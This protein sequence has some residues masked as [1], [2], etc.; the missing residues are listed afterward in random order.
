M[1]SKLSVPRLT[2]SIRYSKWKLKMIAS[3]KRQDLYE[4]S[5]GIGKDSYEYENDC[6]NDNDR[7]FGTICLALSPSFLYLVK[8]VEYPNDLWTKLDRT[9][10]KNNEDHYIKLESTSN[11]TRVL[12]SKVVQ[13]YL[14]GLF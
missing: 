14:V 5:I 1:D 10:G 3:L 6:L 4:V 8:S 7:Y 2:P 12:S 13:P 9:F 11:T